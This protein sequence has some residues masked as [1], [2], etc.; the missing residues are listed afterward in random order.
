MKKTISALLMLVLVLAMF[1]T[2]ALAEDEEELEVTP[3]LISEETED[4]EIEEL[5]A[6]DETEQDELIEQTIEETEETDEELQEELEMDDEEVEEMEKRMNQA[7]A[8][9]DAPIPGDSGTL[10]NEFI[11][12]DRPG[13][14]E[15]VA[16]KELH[17]KLLEN[18]D[19]FIDGLNDKEKYI[20]QNRIYTELPKTLES[21]GQEYGVTRERIRQ[22]E[23]KI[24]KKLKDHFKELGDN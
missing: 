1:S 15:I 6:I 12:D 8:S 18:L 3:V 23:E 24:I 21:I 9:L 2:F 14:D 13:E 17:D 20:F 4:A 19:G 11:S 7:E 10:L 22:I 5:D 16:Q